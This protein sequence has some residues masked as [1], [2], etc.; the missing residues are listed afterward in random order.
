MTGL[1]SF[2]PRRFGCVLC[3]FGE[4][5]RTSLVGTVDIMLCYYC[6]L[7]MVWMCVVILE[8]TTSYSDYES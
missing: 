1:E 5:A 8:S 2:D 6:L 4:H 3:L 7:E